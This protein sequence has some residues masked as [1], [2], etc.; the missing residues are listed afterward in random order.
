MFIA[1][2]RICTISI[3]LWGFPLRHPEV[4]GY[5]ACDGEQ[6]PNRKGL[7]Q[8]NE[9][10]RR[11]KRVVVVPFLVDFSDRAKIWTKLADWKLKHLIYFVA[12]IGREINRGFRGMK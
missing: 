11:W 2:Q 1:N 12:C 6:L 10:M 5:Y 7:P 9:K 4:F 8:T 3:L